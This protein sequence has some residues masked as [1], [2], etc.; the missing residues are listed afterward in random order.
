MRLLQS[1]EGDNNNNNKSSSKKKK[2][3]TMMMMIMKMKKKKKVDADVFSA[4]PY[5]IK[6]KCPDFF[7][8]P[9]PGGYTDRMMYVYVQNDV[10]SIC[11]YLCVVVDDMCVVIHMGVL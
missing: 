6:G 10:R 11:I 1:T 7:L 4:I 5:K 3:K 9:P 8:S 2:K